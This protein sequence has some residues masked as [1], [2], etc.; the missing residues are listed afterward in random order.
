V[1]AGVRAAAIAIALALVAAPASRAQGRYRVAIG[2]TGAAKAIVAEF[3]VCV[4]AETSDCGSW[5]VRTPD[6]DDAP[7]M[8]VPSA[9]RELRS[10]NGADS[11]SIDGDA[12]VIR[13]LV[14]GAKPARNA[15]REST[16]TPRAVAVA[17]DSR[18][19]FV[20]FDGAAGESSVVDMIELRS[21]A[22]ID[23]LI[24]RDHATGIAVLRP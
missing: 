1:T 9:I 24:V 12:V 11:L 15:I 10:P 4:P 8:V 7:V 5:I 14:R 16:H 20:L 2:V 23:T 18:Y 6:A 19:A 21:M 13:S 22:V 17:P 3:R